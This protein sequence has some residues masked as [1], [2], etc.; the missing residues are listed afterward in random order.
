MLQVEISDF[1][2]CDCKREE[3]T[4]ILICDP[5]GHP[6]VLVTEIASGTGFVLS[7]YRDPDFA[8]RLKQIDRLPPPEITR[9]RQQDLIKE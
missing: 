3:G 9:R 2:R 7:D 4:Q 6:L 5:N 1:S 8:D